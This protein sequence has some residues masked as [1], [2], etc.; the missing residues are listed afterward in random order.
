VENLKFNKNMLPEMKDRKIKEKE[1]RLNPK[2]ERNL[3]N[4][5]GGTDCL[6]KI[7]RE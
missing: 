2:Y 1:E 3:Y 6:E 4:G 7:A 5:T